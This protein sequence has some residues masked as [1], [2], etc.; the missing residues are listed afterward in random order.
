MT[1]NLVNLMLARL[2]FP[3][4]ISLLLNYYRPPLGPNYDPYEL[5]CVFYVVSFLQKGGGDDVHVWEFFLLLLSQ[6]ITLVII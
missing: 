4:K 6:V 1:T 5:K 2:V 3:E